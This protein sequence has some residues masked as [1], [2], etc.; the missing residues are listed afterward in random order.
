[1]YKV[2]WVSMRMVRE[3]KIGLMYILTVN[4][5]C[6]QLIVYFEKPSE[7]YIVEVSIL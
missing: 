6:F 4:L 7:F 1:M 5:V 3:Q 2:R